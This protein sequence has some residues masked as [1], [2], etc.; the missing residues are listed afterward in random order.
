MDRKKRLEIASETLEILKQGSYTA[1]EKSSSSQQQQ[2]QQEETW[3]NLQR[4]LVAACDGTC[5]IFPNEELDLPPLVAVTEER[6]TEI[7]LTNETTL[8]CAHR[9]VIS[10]EAASNGHGHGRVGVLNFASAKNPGGSFQRGSWAQE[11]NLAVSTGIYSCLSTKQAKPF[12]E[13]HKQQTAPSDS[14]AKSQRRFGPAAEAA[15]AAAA[16]AAT[17]APTAK[18]PLPAVWLYS[19]NMIYSPH[20][21]V[22]RNGTDMTLLPQPYTVSVIS[23]CAVNYNTG[24]FHKNLSKHDKLY[25]LH[26]MQ[27]RAL[28]VLQVAAHKRIDTLVLGAWGC[29]VFKNEPKEVAKAFQVA[30]NHPDMDGR[31]RRVVFAIPDEPAASSNGFAYVFDKTLYTP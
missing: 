4:V 22:F 25:A 6:E 5:L 7:I 26:V 23:S 12:Y 30:L 21:P 15:A 16:V 17:A 19:S 8:E 31:F 20:V 24:M 13:F 11:E 10:L 2:Q 29:G 9:L 14:K 27:S 28:R 3:I 1:R 18:K